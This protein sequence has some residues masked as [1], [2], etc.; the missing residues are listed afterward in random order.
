MANEQQERIRDLVRQ[1]AEA[2]GVPYPL[3]LSVLEHES[4]YDPRAR[5]PAGARGLMQLMPATA[6]EYN[7]T[8][9][10]DMPQN[11]R[12][13]IQYLAMLLERYHGD[14]RLATAAYNAGPGAVDRASGVPPF[15]E[16]QHY[17]EAVLAR[18]AALQEAPSPEDEIHRR[19]IY[20]TQEQADPSFTG[21][22]LTGKRGTEPLPPGHPQRGG[23]QVSYTGDPRGPTEE[24]VDAIFTAMNPPGFF[25]R[26]NLAEGGA[27]VATLGRD[28]WGVAR[29]LATPVLKG[30]ARVLPAGW[31]A[32]P[33]IAAVGGATGEFVRQAQVPETVDV[34]GARSFGIESWPQENA[35]G[36]DY[37]GAPNTIAEQMWAAWVKALGEGTLEAGGGAVFRGLGKLGKSWK[38]SAFS[39]EDRFEMAGKRFEESSGKYVPAEDAVQPLMDYGI[40]PTKAGALRAA[41]LAKHSNDATTALVAEAQDAI[42]GGVWINKKQLIDDLYE[43]AGVPDARTR[44]LTGTE[45]I[46]EEFGEVATPKKAWAYRPASDLGDIRP[47]GTRTIT[48]ATPDPVPGPAFRPNTRISRR[49]GFKEGAP[50]Q[51]SLARRAQEVAAMGGGTDEMFLSATALNRFRQILNEMAGPGFGK[52]ARGGDAALSPDEQTAMWATRAVRKNL[53]DTVRVLEPSIPKGRFGRLPRFADRLDDQLRRTHQFSNAEALAS[54]VG[55]QTLPGGLTSGMA[56]LGGPLVG[57]TIGGF[58]GGMPGAAV[59]GTAGLVGGLSQLHP[60]FR[61]AVGGAMYRAGTRASSVPANIVRGIDTLRSEGYRPPG[62]PRPPLDNFGGLGPAVE[63]LRNWSPAQGSPPVTGPPRPRGVYSPGQFA[64]PPAS[65]LV[66]PPR[67]DP[68]VLNLILRSLG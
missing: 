24:E 2:L 32:M 63:Q 37:E 65:P 23:I 55:K 47:G 36:I 30:G 20:P 50:L 11:V 62:F 51:A 15:P 21:T 46:T 7:V 40:A 27:G 3:A 57:G 58:Y 4:S 67:P 39:P 68:T 35:V 16:T 28:L 17:V 53:V 54:T 59:G 34:P 19:W 48:K 8:D 6:A 43:N 18:A 41:T 45:A 12:A 61:S 44:A 5:S 52:I 25:T 26:E 42:P 29:R 38:G 9:P 13:G 66:G 33:I 60:R 14:Q 22:N 31:L 49:A 1:N 10:F 56:Y 64:P